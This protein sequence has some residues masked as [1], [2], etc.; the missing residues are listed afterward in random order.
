M[1]DLIQALNES[2]RDGMFH[3]RHV[4]PSVYLHPNY[5]VSLRA[6]Y[7][8]DRPIGET[9]AVAISCEY[10]SGTPTYVIEGTENGAEPDKL[11]LSACLKALAD[12]PCTMYDTV[13]G[14]I[15]PLGAPEKLRLQQVD[16]FSD[17][18]NRNGAS[19][20]LRMRYAFEGYP[21]VDRTAYLD[22]F[23]RDDA[24]RFEVPSAPVPGKLWRPFLAELLKQW[25]EPMQVEPYK[26]DA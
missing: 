26:P 11:V 18:A 16:M 12:S 21:S 15:V 24:W 22:W 14:A 23:P 5:T 25:V 17:P 6:H 19:F 13:P 2:I 20:S 7:I 4:I 9:Y 8:V 1:P 10:R 3:L